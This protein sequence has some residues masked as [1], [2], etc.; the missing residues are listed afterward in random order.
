[1]TSKGT[2]TIAAPIRK[3]LGLKPGQT[4]GLELDESR[5]RVFID[6]GVTP[7]QFEI[8]R[9]RLVSRIPKRKL[10]MSTSALR[11]AIEKAKK[12]EVKRKHRK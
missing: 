4:V 5:Q 3:A 12:A 6:T 2:I 11:E 7:D 10:G 8:A 1:M 9:Q